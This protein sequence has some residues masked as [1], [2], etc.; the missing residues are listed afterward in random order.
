MVENECENDFHYMIDT[1][2]T[3]NSLKLVP[4]L[5]QSEASGRIMTSPVSSG[6]KSPINMSSAKQ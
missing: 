1:P 5:S 6:S 4:K 3:P 2:Q